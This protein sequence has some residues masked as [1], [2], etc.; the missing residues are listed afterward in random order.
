[1][2]RLMRCLT[3]DIAVTAPKAEYGRR[4][5]AGAVVDFDEVI[6]PAQN[7]KVAFTLGDALAG[8]E[9]CF[10]PV[11]EYADGGPAPAGYAHVDV[12]SDVDLSNATI[13]PIDST[14]Q[15]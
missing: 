3:A 15:E 10:E 2:P 1:M 7:G 11:Y 9:N 6:I 14:D 12:D 8:R 5:G 4:M 13:T